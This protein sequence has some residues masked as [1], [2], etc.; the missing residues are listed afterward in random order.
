MYGLT[1]DD[2]DDA[3]GKQDGEDEDEVFGVDVQQKDEEREVHDERRQYHKRVKHLPSDVSSDYT[4]VHYIW[5]L[6]EFYEKLFKAAAFEIFILKKLK[7]R[8]VFKKDKR[9]HIKKGRKYNTRLSTRT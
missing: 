7:T 6:I 9:R 8:N 4:F 3:P 1:V 5:G 2:S